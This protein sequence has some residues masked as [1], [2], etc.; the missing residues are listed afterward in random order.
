MALAAEKG[1]DFQKVKQKKKAK[2][3]GK[4]KEA[5]GGAI[6]AADGEYQEIEIEESGS[7]EEE[8]AAEESDEDEDEEPAVRIDLV[9]LLLS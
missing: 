1:V 8:D 3:A 5:S 2:E 7:A 6:P 4:R 9:R